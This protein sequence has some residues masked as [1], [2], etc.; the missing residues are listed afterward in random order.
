MIRESKLFHLLTGVL[1]IWSWMFATDMAGRADQITSRQWQYLMS[2][3]GH[4]WSWTAVFFMAA[5][6]TTIGLLAEHHKYVI[7]AFGLGL[8]SLG[9]LGIGVFYIVAPLIDRGLT[10][11]GYH[12][13]FITG[14]LMLFAAVANWKPLRWY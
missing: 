1:A 12:P 9:A 2:V 10:T 4:Q 6:I 13:W 11:L 3:P 7:R 14:S 8:M 5:V